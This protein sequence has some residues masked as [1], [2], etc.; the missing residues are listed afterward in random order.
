MTNIVGQE[1]Q[2]FE[3]VQ[4]N[5]R[6]FCVIIIRNKY[7][8]ANALIQEEKNCRIIPFTFDQ[9]LSYLLSSFLLNR[10]VAVMGLNPFMQY[11]HID[12][13]RYIS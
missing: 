10:S 12:S 9:Q 11:N 2:R 8:S 7:L 4:Y 13:I 6:E 5:D 1:K 3:S